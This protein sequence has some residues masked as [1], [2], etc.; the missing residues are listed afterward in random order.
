M[1][2]TMPFGRVIGLGVLLSVSFRS[3]LSFL[4]LIELLLQSLDLV[5][6]RLFIRAECL[7]RDRN[8]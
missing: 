8:L 5:D 1:F 4:L 2:E 7:P 3:C 6:Q